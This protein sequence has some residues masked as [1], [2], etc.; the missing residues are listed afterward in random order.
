MKLRVT[1]I[2]CWFRYVKR[3]IFEANAGREQ[4]Y[5]TTIGHVWRIRVGMQMKTCIQWP[6]SKM[7]H[8][9]KQEIDCWFLYVQL[10]IFDTNTARKQA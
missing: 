7:E 9:P 8:I 2:V 3:H 5:H 10:R 1:E 6:H 4:E